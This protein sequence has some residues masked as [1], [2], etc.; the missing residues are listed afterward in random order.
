MT[1]YTNIVES[2]HD[3]KFDLSANIDALQQGKETDDHYFRDLAK[4]NREAWAK[5]DRVYDTGEFLLSDDVTHQIRTLYTN[6]DSAGSY[7]PA[8]PAKERLELQEKQLKAVADCLESI[9]RT[10]RQ[11]LG[12]QR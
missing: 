1:A 6:H 10:A 8:A 5:L 9:R 4:R 7:D 12:L 3:I 2:L 11:D